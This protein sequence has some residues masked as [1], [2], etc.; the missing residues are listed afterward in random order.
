[1]CD[2]LVLVGKVSDGQEHGFEV[3]CVIAFDLLHLETVDL[4]GGVLEAQFYLCCRRLQ[5]FALKARNSVEI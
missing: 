4:P 1:M 2:I 3:A 5:E